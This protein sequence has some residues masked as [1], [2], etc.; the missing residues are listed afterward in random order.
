[1]VRVPGSAIR[2][3]RGAV[4]GG[5]VFGRLAVAVA[6]G[7]LGGMV[8]SCSAPAS[9]TVTKRP[10]TGNQYVVEFV[11]TPL[12]E[13]S[14]V[15]VR[16]IVDQSQHLLR[17]VRMNVPATHFSDFAGDGD[18]EISDDHAVWSTPPAGGQLSW[19][20]SVN[21]KKSKSAY[22]AYMTDDWA[23][24][25]ASDIIPP[26]ATRTIAGASSRTS[27]EFILPPNWSSMT[28][29]EGTHHRYDVRNPQRRYDRPTGWILLGR[30]GTRTDE[31]AGTRVTVAAP[32]NHDVRRLDMLAMLR[33][34]MPEVARVFTDFPARLTVFSANSPMWR[35]GLSAPASVYLHA[36]RPLISENGTSTLLHEV[37]HVGV[38]ASAAAG[39][40]WVI[41]G[42][43]EYFSLQMLLRSGTISRN[44]YNAA[45]DKL[46]A[47]GRGVANLCGPSSSGAV[48]AR[49]AVLMHKLDQ[50]I[51]A[52][53]K[54][55]KNLD[56]VIGV[57]AA[58]DQKISI[59]DLQTTVEE[60]LEA[61]S[62]VLRNAPLDDCAISG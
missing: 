14:V 6:F 9:E 33:W 60:L 62:I 10:S 61:E 35:G 29:Y 19:V 8:A 1:M 26:A 28:E 46:D 53:T 21:R 7:Y 43:A 59:A 37:I 45:L 22:D 57:L 11:V 5:M 34:T 2:S 40:D 55:E 49:A 27:I 3:P 24:F 16:M 44:R 17:E 47:W 15:E 36:D 18:L 39:A 25:R 30:I 13:Q 56:D 58:G 4:S 12:P 20:V 23:L 50:E 54:N 41:E 51:Q 31:I 48:T 32:L 38:G 52:S 42:V